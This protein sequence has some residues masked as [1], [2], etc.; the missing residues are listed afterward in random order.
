MRGAS[1]GAISTLVERSGQNEPCPSTRAGC[2]S[3]VLG[4][5]R[6][7]APRKGSERDFGTPGANAVL[8][9]ARA[10]Q[11]VGL[12]VVS[13]MRASGKSR[14]WRSIRRVRQCCGTSPGKQ[15]VIPAAPKGPRRPAAREVP[16]R[17]VGARR[18]AAQRCAPALPDAR[19][20]GRRSHGRG[21]ADMPS[22]LRSRSLSDRL[23][24]TLCGVCVT[25]A[26]IEAKS[27]GGWLAPL[28]QA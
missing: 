2:Q 14:A 27:T 20:G 17:R 4:A 1:S 6:P 12:S 26:Q 21:Y 18:V 5:F 15:A 9:F 3:R 11:S 25:G 8:L 24:R 23:A 10:H 19:A 7:L 13:T 22:G 28:A 16:P